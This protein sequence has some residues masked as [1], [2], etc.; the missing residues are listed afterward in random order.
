MNLAYSNN[1]CGVHNFQ[2]RSTKQCIPKN[3]I[4]DNEVDCPDR[5]D[6]IG[7]GKSNK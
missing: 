2:C 6:E 7:C 1:G 5:S 3:Y 4:C